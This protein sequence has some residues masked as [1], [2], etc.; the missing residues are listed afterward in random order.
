[1]SQP[2]LWAGFSAIVL[3]MLALDLGVFQRRAHVVH[4]REAAV[5]CVVWLALAAAFGAGLAYSMGREH[6]MEFA[7]GYVVEEALSVDNLFVFLLLFGYFKVPDVLRH[8]VLFWGIL[9]A[10]VMR[11][12]MIAGGVALLHYFHWVIYVFGAFLVVTGLRMAV[13]H[14][15]DVEP[16]HNPALR[17]VRRLI[18]V[19]RDYRGQH[20]FVRQRDPALG[21]ERWFATPLFVVLVLVETT[22]LVFAVD[23]IPAVFGV[24]QRPFIVYTSN[25]FAI[26]GLRSLFFLLAGV[27]ARFHLLRFGLAAVLAFVGVKMLVSARWD[28]PIGTSLAVIGCVLAVSVI[29]SLI[30]PPPPA[31]APPTSQMVTNEMPAQRLADAPAAP[32][33]SDGRSG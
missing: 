21:R 2:L 3:G 27:I 11:G 15:V 29:A 13:G 18:P 5:W 25:V 9:G 28:V 12:A 10:L 4:P 22:D 8:R 30:V 31:A 1:M 23:S 14:G 17:L 16:D 20:F 33:P 19:T 26:L 7:A 6:A 24:T 32:A